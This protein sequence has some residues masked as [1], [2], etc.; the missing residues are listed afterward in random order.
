MSL[1]SPTKGGH[2]FSMMMLEDSVEA[3]SHFAYRR[4]IGVFV[5]AE[6]MMSALSM[7]PYSFLATWCPG[8][9]VSSASYV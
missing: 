6:N 9:P 5:G 2:A 1:S 4:C 3:R 7:K 8:G